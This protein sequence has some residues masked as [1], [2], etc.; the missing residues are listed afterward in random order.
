MRDISK[1]LQLPGGIASTTKVAN[2]DPYY[3]VFASVEEAKSTVPDALKEVG[4]QFAV[5][6]DG[7]NKEADVYTWA[8]DSAGIWFGK[9]QTATAQPNLSGYATTSYVDGK[10]SSVYKVKGS[11]QSEAKLP[12]NNS[13]GDV[14]NLIDTGE[15]VV[16]VSNLNNT[17][18]PGWDKLGS[19]V[20]LSNYYQKSE[21][22]SRT[23]MDGRYQPK[24]NYITSLDGYATT[25][26]VDGKVSPPTGTGKFLYDANN[27]WV[28]Y[29]APSSVTV[30]NTLTSTS[31]TDALSALQGKVLNDTTTKLTQVTVS[32]NT[33]AQES[34]RGKLILVS[35]TCVITIPASLLAEWGCEI[36]VLQGA[37]LNF[38]VESGVT[39]QFGT[40]ASVP[41]RGIVT[42]V[43]IASTNTFALFR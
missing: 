27:G 9:Q 41:E 6:K 5:Y 12:T 39:W 7:S 25:S 21:T 32:A 23:E 20:N 2:I 24:G 42:L 8:K 3:G 43:K 22:Y 29:V 33:T 1:E 31:T 35:T 30:T 17:G 18:T 26:Y 19:V 10:V 40:P 36:A 16:W 37:V 14:Y 13:E 34:W 28:S 4:R 11:V 15:N 38:A